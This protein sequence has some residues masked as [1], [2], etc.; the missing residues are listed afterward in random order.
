MPES[1]QYQYDLFISHTDKDTDWVENSLIKALGLPAD[2]IITHRRFEK[3]ALIIQEFER[4]ITSSRY[5]FI[6]ITEH[7]LQ[8]KY[9]TFSRV[10]A[11][12]IEV[13]SG[14]IR[15][16]PMIL[17]TCPLPDKITEMKV[18]YNFTDETISWDEHLRS[19]S[20]LLQK[21]LPKRERVLC[22]YIGM[23]EF[24][25]EEQEGQ[26]QFIFCGRDEKINNMLQSIQH[27]DV[28]FVYGPSGSGKS[29]LVLRGFLSKLQRSELWKEDYWL[30]R[31]MRPVTS[32]SDELI[33]QLESDLSDLTCSVRNLLQATPS[34]KELLLIIDQF[35]ELFNLVSPPEIESFL[36]V[37]MK[38]MDIDNCRIILVMRADFFGDVMIR[39]KFWNRIQGSMIEVLP[40]YGEALRKAISYPASQ[41]GVYVQ[42]SLVERIVSDGEGEPG[43]LP[44]LQETMRYL[45]ERKEGPILRVDDYDQMASELVESL[46][47]EFAPLRKTPSGLAAAMISVADAA[48]SETIEVH[49]GNEDCVP[50]I[51]LRL[52]HFD[53]SGRHTRRQQRL[54]DLRSVTSQGDLFEKTMRILIRHRLLSITGGE[55]DV[56]PRVDISHESLV[57]YWSNLREWL[58][59]KKE[60][61]QI[62]RLLIIKVREWEKFKNEG[63]E[64]G[65]LDSAEL[66]EAERYLENVEKLKLALGSIDEINALV[67]ESRKSLELQEKVKA[68]ELERI[69]RMRILAQTQA[70]AS[71]ALN[72]YYQKRFQLSALLAI[73]AYNFNKQYDGGHISQIDEVLRLV[74]SQAFY[75]EKYGTDFRQQAVWEFAFSSDG[76]KIVFTDGTSGV[77]VL[78]IVQVKIVASLDVPIMESWLRKLAVSNRDCVA[79]GYGNGKLLLWKSLESDKRPTR[80]DY[81]EYPIDSIAFSPSGEYLASCS[82]NGEIIIWKVST[83]SRMYCIRNDDVYTNYDPKG[84]HPKPFCVRFDSSGK[85]LYCS[86]GKYGI[87]L[88]ELSS[89]KKTMD[90]KTGTLLDGEFANPSEIALSPNG[91]YL[92]IVD[93][94][95]VKIMEFIDK[96]VLAF[97][98]PCRFPESVSFSFESRNVAF[99]S[100][101]EVSFVDLE[102]ESSEPIILQ[103]AEHVANLVICSPNS[104]IVAASGQGRLTIWSE[105]VT[106]PNV[107][108]GRYESYIDIVG[109]KDNFLVIFHILT[110]GKSPFDFINIDCPEERVLGPLDITDSVFIAEAY[111][112]NIYDFKVSTESPAHTFENI[113][114]FLE[115]HLSEEPNLIIKEVILNPSY[116]VKERNKDRVHFWGPSNSQFVGNTLVSVTFHV[117]KRKGILDLSR[118]QLDSYYIE[119]EFKAIYNTARSPDGEFLAIQSRNHLNLYHIQKKT[120]LHLHYD[121]TN[122]VQDFEFSPDSNF[123]AISLDGGSVEVFNLREGTKSIL[124]HSEGARSVRFS[125]DGAWLAVFGYSNVIQLSN[126]MKPNQ[127]PVL[128]RGHKSKV[129]SIIFSHDSSYLYSCSSDGFVISWLVK[130]ESLVKLARKKV[131]RNLSPYEWNRYIGEDITYEETTPGLPIGQ[132]NEKIDTEHE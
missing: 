60:Y 116:I 127:R 88:Y 33:R 132:D 109:L 113:I 110:D 62:R 85:Q 120:W 63:V 87:R 112:C 16:I 17:E 41:R 30:I 124:T 107:I 51:F 90:T 130:S 21:P 13:D 86:W 105:E 74:C 44:L 69:K 24:G 119:N 92:G 114:S 43:V 49:E 23:K 83:A 100:N 75:F 31:T 56:D 96:W 59:S 78:S 67:S 32:P 111:K 115:D 121:H 118:T 26:D 22:P 65:I 103:A 54:S 68:E 42:T 99:T 45:W 52:I 81:H 7:Y 29:S 3:G 10:L 80:L 82:A 129:T 97:S 117:D 19:I 61:E 98:F 48:Y 11:Q 9:A 12:F 15:L 40:L 6:I 122:H 18:S 37:I 34:S 55:I 2:R 104:R 35:E 108:L 125:P 14:E 4:A 47:N 77:W 101:Y 66:L 72:Q 25:R 76:S 20:D 1:T 131:K 8:D 95:S 106:F 57:L 50:A 28:L 84:R 126:Y 71:E 70:L 58:A 64:G 5:T 89:M 73:Q 91:K 102:D 36:D 128:L 38:L 46:P 27:N 79:L 123:L 39:P 94:E 53:E 93:V